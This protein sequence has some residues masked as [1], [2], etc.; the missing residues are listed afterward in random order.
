MADKKTI[1]LSN[2]GNRDPYALDSQTEGSIITLT[3]LILPDI[4]YLFP[5][6]MQPLGNYSNTEDNAERARIAIKEI[7][8]AA[9]VFLRPLDLPDPTDYHRILNEL[10]RE[11]ASLQETLKASRR[12][13]FEYHVNI[14]SG[15]RRCRPA[16]CYL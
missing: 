2:V 14:S 8:P 4:V 13:F 3:R 10:D 12:Q 11:V 15:T 16:G 1:L 7:L 9:Q 6:A 5:T